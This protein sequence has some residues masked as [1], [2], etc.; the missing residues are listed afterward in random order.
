[1]NRGD[2]ARLAER[3]RI[4]GAQFALYQG[5]ETVLVE[6]GRERFGDG[7]AVT[8][9]SAFPYGSVTKSFT[10]TV[11]LQL[12]SGGDLDLDKP[13]GSYLAELALARNGI[14]HTVTVR[15]LLSHTSGLPCDFP[16]DGPPAPSF[17]RY[18]LSAGTLEPVYRPGTA[19][20]YSNAGYV[21]LGLLID[22]ISWMSW[23][24]AIEALLLDPL[25]IEPAFCADPRIPPRD[26]SIVSG[27]SV[28]DR[29]TIPIQPAIPVFDAPAGA[30]AGSAADLVAFARM[31]LGDAAAL[32]AGPELEL[33]RNGAGDVTAF[34]LASGWGLG[35]A[36]F[37]S[38]SADWFGHDGTTDGTT[39][40]LRFQPES[41]VALALTTNGVN[42]LRLWEDVLAQLRAEGLDVGNYPAATLAGSAP[43]PA[44]PA[45]VGVYRN[46]DIEYAVRP[47]GD[48]GLRVDLD[49]GVLRELTFYSGLR[50]RAEAPGTGEP[51]VAGR[52]LR[53]S[54]TGEIGL[55]EIGG[56][57]ARRSR[58]ERLA[59]V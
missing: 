43:R 30:L 27:H 44:E 21:L 34:G 20:S 23:W 2:L 46:G 16:E 50:F 25:E 29:R 24:D 40:H 28:T 36:R 9:G 31:H 55:M 47:A 18:A 7:P 42:G 56:R 54:R 37:R 22:E 14:E 48:G 33:M 58:V 57:A 53:D 32:L 45:C 59:G 5:G 6:A 12:V 52:F 17:R 1:V 4:P 51:T 26:R 39:C 8:A 13:I 10:A 11:V 35:L 15:Q 19:F 49:D 38:G 3:N 41:R